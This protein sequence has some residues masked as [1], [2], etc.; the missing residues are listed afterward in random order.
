MATKLAKPN[1]QHLLETENAAN[2]MSTLALDVLPGVGSSMTYKL[3]QAGLTT[4]GD[5]QQVSLVRLEMLIGKKM[6]QTLY[7][8]CRGIDPR[9]LV[10]EQ[11]RKECFVIYFDPK[12]G[13]LLT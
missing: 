12:C 6:A 11:V 10:Y 1:G 5:V 2:Y 8:N 13:M 9:P 3:N 7:Q 4:C